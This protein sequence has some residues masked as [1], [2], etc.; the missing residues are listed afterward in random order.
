MT[1]EELKKAL[2]ANMDE[3][4]TDEIIAI[5]NAYCKRIGKEEDAVH[6]MKELNEV[7]AKPLTLAEV[8]TEIRNSKADIHDDYFAFTATGELVTFSYICDDDIVDVD[9]LA[10]YVAETGD[11]LDDAILGSVLDGEKS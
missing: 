9:F 10:E 6:E 4:G 3:M 8:D 1:K 5:H 11:A 2:L 7:L